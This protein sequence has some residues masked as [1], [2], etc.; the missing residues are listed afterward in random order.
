VTEIA[1]GYAPLGCY[2]PAVFY[3]RQVPP[4]SLPNYFARLVYLGAR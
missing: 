1:G 3:L 2:P 4:E